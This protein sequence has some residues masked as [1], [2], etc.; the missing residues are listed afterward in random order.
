[1][2]R[3]DRGI[4]GM[5]VSSNIL[6]LHVGTGKT[7]TTSLQTFLAENN[8]K[9]KD[10]GWCYPDL[11]GDMKYVAGEEPY[12]II[13]NGDI[14]K[15]YA[16]CSRLYRVLREGRLKQALVKNLKASHTILSY[17]GFW[18][19]WDGATTADSIRYVKKLYDNVK[20]IVYLRRQ[21]RFIES[22]WN[23]IIKAGGVSGDHVTQEYSEFSGYGP[24]GSV[25]EFR[26]HSPYANVSTEY[27][28]KLDEIS[29]VVGRENVIVRVFEKGQFMGGRG[30]VISDFLQ[31]L[32]QLGYPIDEKSFVYRDRENESISDATVSFAVRFNEEL[33]KAS[34]RRPPVEVYGIYRS[35]E[36]RLPVHGVGGVLRAG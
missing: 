1:M 17:E 26:A 29:Q 9:L 11:R 30:D 36:D 16:R 28:R 7:G 33:H 32:G 31:V 24:Y 8:E 12:H 20:V 19:E 5:S 3:E 18:D 2:D 15:S 13:Q 22:T 25:Q 14:L 21:D 10:Y 6:L 34:V 4:D 35:I 23:Q 27:K